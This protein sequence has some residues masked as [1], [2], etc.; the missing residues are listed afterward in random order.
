MVQPVYDYPRRYTAKQLKTIYYSLNHAWAIHE[1]LLLFCS[2]S[3]RLFAFH[4]Q[5]S[6]V[7]GVSW[8]WGFVAGFLNIDAL[9]WIFVILNAYQSV[10]IFLSYGVSKRSRQLWKMYKINM[11][12]N[13][14]RIEGLIFR[15]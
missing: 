11:E 13:T 9:W 10:L 14:Q 5:I 3:L 15:K 7:L 12:R 8:L 1:D 6:A 4:F 2:H